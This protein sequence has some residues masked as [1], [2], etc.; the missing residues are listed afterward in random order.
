MKIITQAQKWQVRLINLCQWS[1]SLH[2]E[3]ETDFNDEFCLSM[4]SCSDVY[5]LPA[6]GILLVDL[7]L[8]SIFFLYIFNFGV[9]F[10]E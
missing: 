3:E 8:I 5:L 7:I 1:R 2:T 4:V 9:I 6:E 10:N